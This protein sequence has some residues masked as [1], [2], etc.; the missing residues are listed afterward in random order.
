MEV[1]LSAASAWAD[2]DWNRLPY[3]NRL[4]LE[5]PRQSAISHDPMEL[6]SQQASTKF[7]YTITRSRWAAK[8]AGLKLAQVVKNKDPLPKKAPVLLEFSRR[9][10][11][12]AGRSPDWKTKRHPVVPRWLAT[13]SDDHTVG[14]WIGEDSARRRYRNVEVLRRVLEWQ[15]CAENVSKKDAAQ[16]GGVDTDSATLRNSN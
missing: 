3:E 9:L 11:G 1:S 16:G 13:P 12:M 14:P 4:A 7:H 8:V 6:H 10:P 5:P 15:L 2:A